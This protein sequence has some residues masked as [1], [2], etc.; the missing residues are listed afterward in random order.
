[1]TQKKRATQD[2]RS[3]FEELAARGYEPLMHRVTGTYDFDIAGAGHWQVHS[4]AG[5][6]HV[7]EI[8]PGSHHKG[9]PDCTIACDADE[10]N[11]ILQGRQ[12]LVTA[13]MQGRMQVSGS[14][15]MG[16]GFQ[17]IIGAAPLASTR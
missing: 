12:D 1:M 7:S 8:R 3:F 10:F 9:N 5:T 2:A 14:V 15:A 4:D 11:E 6:L 16:V 13:F 17:R